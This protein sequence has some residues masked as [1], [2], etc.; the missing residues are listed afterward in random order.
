MLIVF[1]L[2]GLSQESHLNRKISV[3]LTAC[4][5]EVALREIG[6]AGSFN[7]SYDA[8][9]VPAERKVSLKADDVEVGLLLNEV[10]GKDIRSKEVGNH[11]ILLRNRADSHEKQSFPDIEVTGLILDASNRMPLK[12]VTVFEVENKWSANSGENGK[13]KL[14]IPTGKKIRSL[15]FSKSGYSDT[16]IFISQATEFQ[17]NVLLHPLEGGLLHLKT[18]TGLVQINSI[19]SLRL[20]NWLTPL[21]TLVNAHN[22]EV[23]TTRSFQASVIPGFS[24]N[25]KMAGSMT[26]H[27][28]VNLLSGYNGS[29]SGFELGGMVNIT[30]KKMRGLQIGGVGNIVGGNGKGLQIGGAFNYNLGKIEGVQLAGLFNYAHDSIRGAQISI[31]TNIAS[32]RYNGSQ[33]SLILNLAL[34][35]VGQAQLGGLVNYARNVNGIQLAGLLNIA[36]SH[37]NG[38]QIAVLMNYATVV[39]GFQLGLI[40]ISNTVERGVPVGLFSYVKEGYHL[41]EISGNEIFYG[42]VAFKSG[43]RKFYNFVQFGIGSDY[44]LQGSYGIGSIFTLK[45]KLSVNTDA[46]AGFVYHPTGTTYQGLLLKFNPAVEYRFMKHFAVFLGPAYNFFLFSKG[47]PSATPRGLST[48]DFYFKSTQ[49]ASIQMWI[50]GTMGVRF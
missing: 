44:K 50:G 43:S 31:V 7:F 20:V 33:I 38:A 48:Y 47:K 27:F 1:P 3:D 13:Y 45:E 10:L 32:G 34:K 30:R 36:R 42:N 26:N 28:S 37:N 40:N 16:I 21:T 9:L 41:F 19:D 23:Y 24:S 29:L 17:I 39:N 2:W 25:R 5:V 14:V 8:D 12:D 49:N 46:S 18:L 11:V 4:S 6:K 15:S 35:N 22:L